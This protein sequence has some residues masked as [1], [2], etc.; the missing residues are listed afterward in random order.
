[1]G[2]GLTSFLV[3]TPV[4]RNAGNK[5]AMAQQRAEAREKKQ[6]KAGKKKKKKQNMNHLL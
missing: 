5:E 6:E 4:S 3:K 2:A 1:L